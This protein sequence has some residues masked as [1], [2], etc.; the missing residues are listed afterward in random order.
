MKTLLSI[1]LLT[2]MATSTVFAET[3]F[4]GDVV[5]KE[6]LIIIKGIINCSA[7]VLDDQQNPDPKKIIYAKYELAAETRKL[8]NILGTV[9]GNSFSINGN[10]DTGSVNI[11]WSEKTDLPTSELSPNR[12]FSSGNFKDETSGV[13]LTVIRNGKATMIDCTKFVR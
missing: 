6:E 2:F 4:M 3:I 9:N 1:G 7:T 12:S 11:N 8:F 10:L 13:D 5:Q